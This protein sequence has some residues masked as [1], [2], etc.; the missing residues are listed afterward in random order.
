MEQSGLPVVDLWQTPLLSANKGSVFQ[1][2]R[3]I[4]QS[5]FDVIPC[6][7]CNYHRRNQILF[8]FV[9]PSAVNQH[10]YGI[11][12]HMSRLFVRMLSTIQRLHRI[13]AF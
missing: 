6:L 5:M 12:A 8:N 10:L 13:E 1:R 2:G 4:C 9:L 3:G 11:L 7:H